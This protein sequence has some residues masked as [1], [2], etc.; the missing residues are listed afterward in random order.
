MTFQE[1]YKK[2]ISLS[3]LQTTSYSSSQQELEASLRRTK[4]LLRLVGTPE[5]HLRFIHIT[6]TSGKGST[7]YMVHEILRNSGIS[8]GTYL[9]PHTTSYLERFLVNDRL[10]DPKIIIKGIEVMSSAYK[11][12]LE[13][14]SPMSFFELSTV[15]SIY[16]MERAGAKYMVLEV[17]CGGRY[18]ATNVIPAPEIAIITNINKDHTKLLGDTL[19][20]IAYEKAGIM[21]KHSTVLCG[22]LRP[23][24]KK[25]FTKEAIKKSAALFFIPPPTENKV[26]AHMGAHQQHNAA[27]AERAAQ[28]LGI[29]Q[30]VIDKTLTSIRPLPCRFE[31]ISTKPHIILDG[32]H[33][34]AKMEATAAQLKELKGNIHVLLGHVTEKPGEEFIKLLAPLAKTIH[35]TRFT[36]SV[37]KAENPITLLKQVPKRKRGEAYLYPFT[38]LKSIKKTLKSNDILIVT[39]SLYLAGE[40]RSEWVSEEKIL[41]SQSSF[42]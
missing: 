11:K 16:A 10:I 25:I 2:L 34:R 6:G 1:A 7:A 22:E 12:L 39:G 35:T 40:L 37:R 17:G 4:K 29:D 27:F 3:N 14:E 23:S 28:E 13:E 24:L 21:K 31:T 18:D 19:A 9:S 15:L 42:V 5:Q 8:V 26:A 33:S 41:Q 38:A 32:A 36:T 30:Q 20:Q